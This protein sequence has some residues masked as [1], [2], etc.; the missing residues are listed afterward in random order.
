MED[1]KDRQPHGEGGTSGSDAG[2]LPGCGLSLKGH[3]GFGKVTAQ[4]TDFM[5]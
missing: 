1:E 4:A 3:H 5:S 2:L